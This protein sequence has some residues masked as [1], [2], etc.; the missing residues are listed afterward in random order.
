MS[1]LTSAAHTF[2]KAYVFANSA[3]HMNMLPAL[4]QFLHRAYFSLFVYTWCKTIDAGYFT[5]WQGLTSKLARK[6]LSASIETAK[7][8][9]RLA[10]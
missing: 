7:V 3:Y 1:A 6:H 4:V 10:S 5:T 9:L 8:H 2:L